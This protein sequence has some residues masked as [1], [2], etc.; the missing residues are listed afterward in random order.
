[1]T[2]TGKVA[3][4][5]PGIGSARAPKAKGSQPRQ[6]TPCCVM[7]SGRSGCVESV[8]RTQ[9]AMRLADALLKDSAFRSRGYREVRIYF[10]AESA[11]TSTATPDSTLLVC[12]TWRCSG[13]VNTLKTGPIS[14][15]EN[16][17]MF[18][19]LDS[20]RPNL[21]APVELWTMLHHPQ[22]GL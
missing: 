3:N 12:P 10:R 17:L 18:R 16:R 13:R 2:S 1:M 5:T 21:A 22:N 8:S 6:R 19:F 4:A 11:R 20:N 9:A 15:R 7:P 14:A